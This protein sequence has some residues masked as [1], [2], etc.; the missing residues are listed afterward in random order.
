[1]LQHTAPKI[2]RVK[3]FLSAPWTRID[4]AALQLH[5]FITSALDAGHW[6]SSGRGRFFSRKNSC[7]HWTRGVMSP[8]EGLDVVGVK[9]YLLTL[10]EVESPDRHYTNWASQALL[11]PVQLQ[12]IRF[13][14][15]RSAIH[16]SFEGSSRPD[17]WILHNLNTDYEN[18]L[19]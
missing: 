11:Y 10:S 2:R 3:L 17:S 9:K 19:V 14:Q 7:I 5:T 8:E 12:F 4:R 15:R 13:Y 1:M 16:V 18:Q 6:P